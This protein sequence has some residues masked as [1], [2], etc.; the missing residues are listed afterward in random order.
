MDA[1]LNS[2]LGMLSF[3]SLFHVIGAAGLGYGLRGVWNWLRGKEGGRGNALFLIVWGAGFGGI[4]FFFG[5]DL[6]RQGKPAVF[7]GEVLVWGSTFLV[8][9]LAWDEVMEWLRPFLHPDVFLVAF[10]GI[11]M[12]AGAAAGSFIVREDPLFALLF[13]GLFVVIGGVIYFAGLRRLLKQTG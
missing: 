5:L 9:L 6:A 10:G 7:L 13:G 1:F 3:L 8:A 11:F 12:L 2:P 4:P